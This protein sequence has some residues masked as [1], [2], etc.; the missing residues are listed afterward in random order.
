MSYEILLKKGSVYFYA[1]FMDEN[2][3]IPNIH[4][5]V[6]LGLDPDHGHIFE[7]TYGDKEQY[8][9]PNGISSNVLDNKALSEWLLEEH[10]PNKVGREYVYKVV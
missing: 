5:W 10:S 1:G 9:F 8:C 3:K 4:T 7:S 2:L 6:Y